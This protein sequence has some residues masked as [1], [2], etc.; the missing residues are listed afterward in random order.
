MAEWKKHL[1]P[2]VNGG[3]GL[4]P[5][6]EKPDGERVKVNCDAAFNSATGN[7][8]WGCVLRDA[9]GDVVTVRRG[10]VESLM[11]AFHGDLISGIQGA[12]AA[13]RLNLELA[14]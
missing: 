5:K 14:M 10:R 1:V 12:Q 13:R 4:R 6:W 9:N 3:A 8:G 11:H 2:H 7:G